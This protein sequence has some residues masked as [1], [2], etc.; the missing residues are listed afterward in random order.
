MRAAA[1]MPIRLLLI[2]LTLGA[3]TGPLSSRA[4][5][6]AQ[7]AA[8]QSKDKPARPSQDAVLADNSVLKANIPYGDDELQRLD[9]YQPQGAKQAPV[10]VFVH[11]GAWTRGDKAAVSFKPKLLN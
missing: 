7:Q 9:V 3:V 2:A 11:G 6:R 4:R 1:S 10:V 8:P 5:A